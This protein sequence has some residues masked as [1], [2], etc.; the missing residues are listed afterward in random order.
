MWPLHCHIGW[1]LSEG[2]LAAIVVQPDA[3]KGLY[4]P[5]AWSGVSDAAWFKLTSSS[6]TVSI[7]RSLVRPN[8]DDKTKRV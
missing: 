4:K 6:A 7:S 2:K 3:V 5:P 1:H 8:R